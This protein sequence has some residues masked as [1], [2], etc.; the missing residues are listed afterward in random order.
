MYAADGIIAKMT[1][2]D[3]L[4]QNDVEFYAYDTSE[5]PEEI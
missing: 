1:T 4:A 5:F 3:V 2:A